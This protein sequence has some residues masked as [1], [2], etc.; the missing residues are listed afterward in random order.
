MSIVM[1]PVI[2]Y[3]Y[4][5]YGKA[6]SIRDAVIELRFAYLNRQKYMS[7]G[8]RIYPKE[9]DSRHQ[10][11]IN[12]M[13]AAILNKTLDKL[14]I[15]VRQVI[16][17]MIEDGHIDI[18]AIPARLDAKR[19]KAGTFPDFV[20]ERLP[21]HKHGQSPLR[22]K[23]YDRFFNFLDEYGK[24][25]QFSD[26]NEHTILEL[27][28]Y[29]QKKK[30]MASSRWANYHRFLN[31]FIRDAQK[32]NLVTY[33]PYD[34]IRI[35][36]GDD[37]QS[38]E[39]H[40][41]A[42]ELK[43]LRTAVMP[44]ERLD[45]VRDLFVFQCFTCMA[46]V[47]LAAF[48]AEKVKVVDGKDMILGQRGKTGVE[49]Q[50]PLL[51]PAKD[52]LDKY[53]GQLPAALT[54]KRKGRKGVMTNQQYN[55]AL[56]EVVEAAGLTIHVTTHWASHTGATMLLNAGVEMDVIAKVGGWS[57]TKVLRRIYA[58]LHPETVVKAVNN[59]EDKLV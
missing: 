54:A 45:R 38:I 5:R 13:D 4:N 18:F 52:I 20:K 9:W 11:V 15:E 36:K 58:K 17:D 43:K 23:A 22:Q 3:I 47:D 2:T 6:S 40:L 29:L 55:K 10:R 39:K 44:S 19:K 16:Y 28:R 24:F 32:E 27:D 53:D 59:I 56:K 33:N 34:R 37:S 7:T 57:D 30:M 25:R 31:T 50:I 14:M 49:Y 1:Q 8:I 46:Y 35:D 21:I 48:S 51:R 42:E 26:V 41:S 12:R